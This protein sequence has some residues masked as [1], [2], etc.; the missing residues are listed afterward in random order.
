MN[1]YDAYGY[2]RSLE[3][4]NFRSTTSAAALVS[5]DEVKQHVGIYEDD[6]D[7]QIRDIL[8]PSATQ[9]VNSI[10]GEF[11]TSTNV[12]AFYSNFAR[13]MSIPHNFIDR[14]TAIRYYNTSHVLTVLP[15]SNYVFDDTVQPHEIVIT[16]EP[17]PNLSDRFDSPVRIEYEAAIADERFNTNAIKQATLLITADLWNNRESTTE[18][19]RARAVRTAERILAPI[20]RILI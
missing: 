10:V 5:L 3:A 7:S 14:I 18:N 12:V 16:L 2:G 4:T 8:I 20:T 15:A 6:F 19:A 13:N 11:A 1:Y 9:I 17:T